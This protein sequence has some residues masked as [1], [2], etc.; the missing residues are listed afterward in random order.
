MEVTNEGPGVNKP[1]ELSKRPTQRLTNTQA[2]FEERMLNAAVKN[3]IKEGWDI[4][5]EVPLVENEMPIMI[6]RKL[7]KELCR[8]RAVKGWQKD[9]AR[10]IRLSPDGDM[11][12]D[13]MYGL[14]QNTNADIPGVL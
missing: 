4:F 11:I 3:L 7:G 2:E 10:T 14:F 8:M 1:L 13:V 12:P 5:M 9:F 6:L